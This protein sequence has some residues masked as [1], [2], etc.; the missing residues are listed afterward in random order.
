MKVVDSHQ[1]PDVGATYYAEKVSYL[2]GQ[3]LLKYVGKPMMAIVT[4]HT[5]YTLNFLLT[6]GHLGTQFIDN[7]IYILFR[8]KYYFSS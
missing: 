6:C 2:D 3:C 1:N 5:D 4:Q 8:A 7:K